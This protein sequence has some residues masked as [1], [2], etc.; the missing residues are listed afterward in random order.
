MKTMTK[1][2]IA[3]FV[4]MSVACGDEV[5]N[6]F[7]N[8]EI[9]VEHGEVCEYYK[10][11]YLDDKVDAPSSSRRKRSELTE[12]KLNCSNPSRNACRC[13]S[14]EDFEIHEKWYA[15]NEC[16]EASYR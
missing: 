12:G 7:D 13:V 4:M 5:P 9:P 11:V 8:T 1:F 16:N 14:D 2:L 6:C 15:F 3:M 10:I